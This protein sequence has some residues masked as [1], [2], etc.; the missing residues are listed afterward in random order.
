MNYALQICVD[1]ELIEPG[2]PVSD[3]DG[4]MQLDDAAYALFYRFG[5]ENEC[6]IIARIFAATATGARR[7]FFDATAG[8]VNWTLVEEVDA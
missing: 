6:E 1:N 4:N 3:W 5:V 7:G 8:A 2:V